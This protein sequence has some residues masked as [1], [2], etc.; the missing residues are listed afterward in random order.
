MYDI[1]LLEE[2]WK[3]YKR[4]KRRPWVVLIFSIFF[5]FLITLTLLNYKEIDFLELNDRSKSER[6]TTHSTVVLAD[7]ALATKK[8]KDTN[9]IKEVGVLE[10]TERKP[11][12]MI[13]EN[14][15][16][17]IIE[18]LPIAEDVKTIKEP[19]V[20]IKTVEKPRKKMYLNIIESTSVSAY[21][22]V[23]RR[24]EQSHDTDDSLFLAKSYYTQKSYQ[25][26]EYWA[27]QTNKVNGNIEESWIIFAK[28]KVKLGRKNE[29]IHILTNYIKKSNSIEAQDLLNKIK[30]GTF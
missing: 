12:R 8:T 28:S 30:E 1:K 24:F 17:E 22:D 25:K 29:A 21:K 23:Q 18:N 13:S 6:V 2:E 14:S 11:M 26:A 7:D 27:L 3:K 19:T 4:K 15:S 10:I 5:I 16:M 9:K 20:K